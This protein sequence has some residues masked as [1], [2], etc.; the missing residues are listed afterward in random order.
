M[1]LESKAF[2]RGIAAMGDKDLD[3]SFAGLKNSC[4]YFLRF[5]QIKDGNPI[6]GK[7]LAFLR[8]TI[9]LW[10]SLP[11]TFNMLS[12]IAG[13]SKSMED[14]KAG[15]EAMRWA[16]RLISNHS[17]CEA[18]RSPFHSI[19][20]GHAP[21]NIEVLAVC[22]S[23]MSSPQ[24]LILLVSQRWLCQLQLS[25][26]GCPECPQRID[27]AVLV[28]NGHKNHTLEGLVIFGQCWMCGWLQRVVP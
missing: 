27:K 24:F 4:T 18:S 21:N 17:N 6:S 1:M 11:R 10:P 28:L 13:K 19:T 8:C 7:A 2:S 9:L 12:E 5:T 26:N 23:R 25:N 16:E 20:Q 15:D 3:I 22:R 14:K